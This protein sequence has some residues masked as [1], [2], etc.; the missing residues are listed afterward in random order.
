MSKFN[1]LLLLSVFTF[2]ILACKKEEIDK[3]IVK[4]SSIYYQEFSIDTTNYQNDTVY[5]D[6]DGDGI[7]DLQVSRFIEIKNSSA[8]YEGK[9]EWINTPINFCYIKTAPEYNMLKKNDEIN[10]TRNLFN[11]CPKIEYAGTTPVFNDTHYWADGVFTKYFGFQFPSNQDTL[12]GWFSFKHFEL[13][14]IAINTN[15]N[16]PIKV[17]QKE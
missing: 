9:F 12:Y 13:K 6:I 3:N 17:G 2:F 7:W 1:Y 8:D 10:G 15:S 16:E 4:S 14:E 5:Y 11:W